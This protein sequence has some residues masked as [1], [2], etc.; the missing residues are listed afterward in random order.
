MSYQQNLLVPE[1]QDTSDA[2]AE[3]VSE[4]LAEALADACDV[5]LC[6]PATQTVGCVDYCEVCAREQLLD[7]LSRAALALRIAPL[8]DLADL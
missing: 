4:A 7:W 8:A 1:D 2:L 5:C 3:A 6:R